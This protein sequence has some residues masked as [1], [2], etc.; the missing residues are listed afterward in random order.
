MFDKKVILYLDGIL[1]FTNIDKEH[2]Q[3]L[4][5]VFHHLVHYP[6][7]VKEKKCAS[8]L[9]KVKFVGHIVAAEG[10]SV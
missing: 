3:V 10:I 8:F 2:H 7:Y 4:E 5:E 1:L 9:S 6:L